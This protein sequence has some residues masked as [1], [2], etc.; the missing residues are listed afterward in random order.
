[1]AEEKKIPKSAFKKGMI[2]WNKG[3][4]AK[5]NPQIGVSALKA[6]LARK[7]KAPWNKGK[8]LRPLT[9]EHKQKIK[10]KMLGNTNGFK[11]GN[12]GYWK[13]KKRPEVLGWLSPIEKGK[14]LSMETE[15]KNGSIPSNFKGS[16]ANYHAVHHWVNN[17]LG[18]P[19]TCQHCGKSKLNGR[20]IQWANK[21]HLYKRELTD[22]IRLCVSCHKKYDKGLNDYRKRYDISGNPLT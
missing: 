10:E 2:P 18:K 9:P 5:D 13:G 4:T 11:S 17:H 8:K 6:Q 14:R 22:W 19:D 21:S 1:M 16:A 3:L 12:P 20:Q 7:G 15:F